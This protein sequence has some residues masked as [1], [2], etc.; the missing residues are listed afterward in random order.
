MTTP[1]VLLPFFLVLSLQISAQN[2]WT[3]LIPPQA[4]VYYEKYAAVLYDGVPLWDGESNKGP[5]KVLQ[6]TGKLSV[7]E[8]DRKTNKP[9]SGKSLGFMIGLKDHDTNTTWMLS[10]KVFYEIDLVELQGKLDYGDV[11]II[12]TIDRTYRLPR[13]EVILDGGC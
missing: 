11:L 6:M 1:K 8:V 13:H 10:Q 4:E 9:V 2:S 5:L 3:D 7:S 12:M